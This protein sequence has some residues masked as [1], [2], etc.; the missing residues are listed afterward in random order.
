MEHFDRPRPS[1]DAQW[2]SPSDTVDLREVLAKFWARKRLI[3]TS[4]IICAG[5]AFAIAK[6]ITPIYSSAA[7]V[8]IK[9]QPPSGPAGDPRVQAGIQGGPE[10]VQT[11]PFVLQS[12]ALAS[13]TIELL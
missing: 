9:A 2:R 8:M 4:I 7:Y 10:A 1:D 13:E 3:F 6:L 12:R 5:L 11:Q